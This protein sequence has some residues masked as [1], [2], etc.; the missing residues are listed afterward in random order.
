[1]DFFFGVLSEASFNLAPLLR[2]AEIELLLVVL[3]VLLMPEKPFL[4]KLKGLNF[5]PF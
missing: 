2:E 3:V 4:P 1:M 5:P